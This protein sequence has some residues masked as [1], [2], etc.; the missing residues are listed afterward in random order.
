MSLLNVWDG[1]EMGAPS[2]TRFSAE[3]DGEPFGD[4]PHWPKVLDL[5]I[6]ELIQA[7][8]EAEAQPF[9]QRVGLRLADDLPLGQP[10]TLAALESEVNRRLAQLSWGWCSIRD[11]GRHLII[12]HGDYPLMGSGDIGEAGRLRLLGLSWILGSLYQGWLGAQGGQ[13]TVSYQ[14]NRFHQSLIFHYGS[15]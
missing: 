7:A 3:P 11:A 5:L 9:L 6:D 1:A 10:A 12:E 13:A 15:A 4:A 14:R 8:G 2:A